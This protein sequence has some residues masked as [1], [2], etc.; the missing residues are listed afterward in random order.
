[1]DKNRL[2]TFTDGVM[3]IIMT[4]MVLDLKVPHNPTWQSYIDGY[5]IFLSYALSF[6]L[7]D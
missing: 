2:E 1:M 6:L 7:W 5:P 3:A 4:I